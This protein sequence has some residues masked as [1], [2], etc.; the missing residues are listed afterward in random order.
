M[1]GGVF[2]P[3]AFRFP[4]ADRATRPAR[5]Q[6]AR[7]CSCR[8][9]AVCSVAHRRRCADPRTCAGAHLA[10]WARQ[11]ASTD[12]VVL[13]I[14]P[15]SSP[16][17]PGR[18]RSLTPDLSSA[19][20]DGRSFARSVAPGTEGQSRYT[21]E[22]DPAIGQPAATQRQAGPRRP[23]AP[24]PR[25]PGPAPGEVGLPRGSRWA[26]VPHVGQVHDLGAAFVPGQAR[27]AGRRRD[28]PLSGGVH[29]PVAAQRKRS[30]VEQR[31]PGPVRPVTRRRCGAGTR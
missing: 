13:R 9:T 4:T 30:S 3:A 31:P 23:S 7:R 24:D 6:T 14:R 19:T 17:A 26:E 8:R 20:A 12:C 5:L 15:D 2:R 25:L 28:V 27:R 29:A 21:G 18:V 11:S 10:P 16:I 1:R 22:E